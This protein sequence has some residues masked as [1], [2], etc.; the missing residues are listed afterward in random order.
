MAEL[1]P[2][3]LQMVGISKSFPGVRALQNVDLSVRSGEC[4]ALVGENGAGKS[5][6][7]KILSGVY[8]AD[9]GTIAIDGHTVVPSNPHHAQQLGVSIIYQ[10]FNLFPN[11]SVEE[12]IFI[13]REPNRSGF[14]DRAQMREFAQGF[15]RQ[16]GVDLDPRA[17][18]RNL[19]VAQQQMVEIAKALSYNARI[20]IMDEPTSALTDTEVR[21]LFEIIRGLKERGLG[22]V[23]VSHRLEEIFEICDRITVLRDG[24]NAGELLTATSSP[25]QG[26]RM[27]VGREVTDLYQKSG[28]TATDRI[29][30]S[31]RGLSR[32]GT[33]QDD[34]KVVLDGVD[35]DVRA[36]EIVGLAGLVGSGRTEVARAI[37]GADHFDSGEI[38]L[39]GQRIQ[40]KSPSEAIGKGIALAPEDRKLQALVLALAI[41]ENIALP[42]LGRLSKF[43]FVKRREERNLAD[44]YIQALSVRTPSMEQKVVNLSGG[45]QQKVVLAKWLALSPKV[46]IVDEPTRGI[47]IGAKAEVHSLLSQLA[48]QG[49]AV[50]M[51]SSELPEI[52]GMSDRIYVMRE[53]KISGV[54]DRED[55]TE[56]RIMELATGVAAGA[57]AA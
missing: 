45:N 9:E 4:L 35:L 23:F 13:G 11:M 54:I 2:D 50:L 12:N 53:G 39:D 55:A 37:F 3:L 43:G 51:I 46:L 47:D 48:A 57:H 52:L 17:M 8:A 27:M 14:V 34:S 33:Q 31:V 28:S 42:N 44:K 40:V 15:L 16:V 19:S 7:M 22:I 32:S 41:R 56:E 6:L 36:G 38:Y 10:E 30:L 1:T 49:V 20:V 5:T 24:R 26:G 25:D 29:V 18:V 21:A